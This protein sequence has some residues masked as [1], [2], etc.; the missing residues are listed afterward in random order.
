M[1]AD[2]TDGTARP[3]VLFVM[4]AG[5]SG[6]TI[7]GVTL[8][9]CAGVFYAGEVDEWLVSSG[10]PPWQ[11]AARREFWAAVAAQ[12]DGADIYGSEA[13]R[14][15]ER[16]SSL[17][18]I[19]RWPGRRRIRRRYREVSE[20]LLRAIASTA[21]V[22]CVVDTSHFPL[23]AR[24]LRRLSGVELY[25]VFLVRDARAVVDSNLREL[26]PH[27]VAERRVRTLAMLGNLTLTL[28]VSI[29]VFATHPRERRLF[30]RHEDFLAEPERALR[31]ILAMLGSGAS[32]PDLSEL[33]VGAPIEG[34]RLLRSET[35][36]L[37][38]RVQTPPVPSLP[39]AVLQ[40]LCEPLL[41]R[42]RP[43][44]GAAAEPA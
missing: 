19:D 7:L 11:D 32:L 40:A 13:A 34:N 15:I 2:A 9:N 6:S 1:S 37:Q 42:L 22:G 28:A 44:F 10:T 12:V 39:A 43:A 29:A 31:A 41:R 23:R 35:I 3:K 38:R 16:S 20:Q 27:E 36:S 33:R 8:G 4:G 14:S 5:H 24:E 21:G 30:L 18:R 25:I 17:L 26:R